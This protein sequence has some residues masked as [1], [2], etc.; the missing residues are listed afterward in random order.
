MPTAQSS[1]LNCSVVNPASRTI[2]AIVYAS[3]GLLRGTTT[4]EQAV[5][6]EDVLALAIDAEAGLLQR[7]DGAQVINAEKLRHPLRRNDLNF[8]TRPM[9]R[10]RSAL[11]AG[12]EN[13]RV[14]TR[15]QLRGT[16]TVLM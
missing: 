15:A 11:A 4:R 2:A 8:T 16:I 3:T 5:R 10:A 13:R 9:K 12:K 7:F 14:T 1:S 6:H